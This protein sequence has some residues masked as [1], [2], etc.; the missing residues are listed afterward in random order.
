MPA[1]GDLHRARSTDG[2]SFGEERRPVAADDLDSWPFPQPGRDSR[3]LSI[4]QQIDGPMRF[5]VDDDSAVGATL[6]GGVL[7]DSDRAGRRRLRFGQ[8][9]DQA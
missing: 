2:S 5:Q 3:R 7:V 1:I 9:A 8:S 4:G 6:A